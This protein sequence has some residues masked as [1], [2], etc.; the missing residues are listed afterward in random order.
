MQTF[1]IICAID[2]NK[3]LNLCW[4]KK[5]A[6]KT[7]VELKFFD[8][9]RILKFIATDTTTSAQTIIVKIVTTGGANDPH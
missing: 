9:A 3:F 8:I 4:K 2:R 5:F 7:V 6:K 1:T